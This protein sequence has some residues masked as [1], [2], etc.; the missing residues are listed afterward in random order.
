[1]PCKQVSFSIGAVMG[2]LEGVHLPEFLR[3][4]KSTSGFLS[5][6]QKTLRFYVSLEAIW[7]FS[8]EQGYPE[9]IS[10]CG[11]QRAHL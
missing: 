6:T 3:E 8:K 5:R 4:R 10:D 2:D 9:L 1:M 7:N 11:A